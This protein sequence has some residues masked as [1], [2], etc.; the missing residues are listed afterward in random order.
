MIHKRISVLAFMLTTGLASY[1]CQPTA[2]RQRKEEPQQ[3]D[4]A[5]AALSDEQRDYTLQ[6]NQAIR[7]TED[8][9]SILRSASTGSTDAEKADYDR[10]IV[11]LVARRTTLRRDFVAISNATTSDWDG[12]KAKVATD[13]DDA[14]KSVRTASTRV[15]RTPREAPAMP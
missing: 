10:T 5:I 3:G 8:Q 11:D 12:V 6:I 13:L 2:D 4:Q 1:G 7:D 15:K 14:R 9:L